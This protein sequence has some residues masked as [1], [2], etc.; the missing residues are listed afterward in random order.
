MS[1]VVLQTAFF[2]VQARVPGLMLPQLQHKTLCIKAGTVMLPHR[3]FQAS[4]L[5]HC[6]QHGRMPGIS[7]EALVEGLRPRDG[8][9]RGAGVQRQRRDIASQDERPGTRS[10]S[11]PCSLPAPL[12]LVEALHVNTSPDCESGA[13]NAREWAREVRQRHLRGG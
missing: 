1:E 6:T 3:S 4:P 13:G 2:F 7:Q 11:N 8:L 9:L 10:S 12:P 5:E